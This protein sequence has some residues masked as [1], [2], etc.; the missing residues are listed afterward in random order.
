M[1]P[2]DVMLT[3]ALILTPYQTQTTALFGSVR[4]LATLTKGLV[5]VQMVALG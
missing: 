4:F 1:V 5:L 3:K 2:T